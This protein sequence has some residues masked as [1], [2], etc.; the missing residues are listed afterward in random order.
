MGLQSHFILKLL[1]VLIEL[2]VIKKPYVNTDEEIS[3]PNKASLTL[4]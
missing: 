2:S 3:D 1:T 4:H